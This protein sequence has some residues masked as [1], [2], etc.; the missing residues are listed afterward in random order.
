MKW[1]LGFQVSSLG[2]GEVADFFL[3][4]DE[5]EGTLGSQQI[6]VQVTRWGSYSHVATWPS[7]PPHEATWTPKSQ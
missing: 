3:G 5:E 1:W 7:P 2:R 6:G 4:E